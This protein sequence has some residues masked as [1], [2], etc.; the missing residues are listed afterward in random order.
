[1]PRTGKEMMMSLEMT[2][3]L[4]LRFDDLVGS[5]F[6]SFQL[7]LPSCK[8]VSPYIHNLLRFPGH[9]VGS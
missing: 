9:E 4:D 1:M 3:S 7:S 6:H 5:E 2:E 8:S